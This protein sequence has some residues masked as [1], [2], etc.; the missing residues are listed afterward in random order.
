MTD[1]ELIALVESKLAGISLEEIDV[2]RRRM[3][4]SRPCGGRS[5][6]GRAGSIPGGLIGK[7]SCRPRRF[8]RGRAVLVDSVRKYFFLGSA[9]R[10]SIDARLRRLDARVGVFHSTGKDGC[11]PK[12]ATRLQCRCK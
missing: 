1:K 3:R 11:S 2:V 6:P 4:A 5:R 8:S 9:G 10:L 12:M 7:S